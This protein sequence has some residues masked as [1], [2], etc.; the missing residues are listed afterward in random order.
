ML[1]WIR[2][3]VSLRGFLPV[4]A[5]AGMLWALHTCLMP[6]RP[7]YSGAQVRLVEQ[8]A[9]EAARWA[10]A[11]PAGC[12]RTVFGNLE[13]D[14][15]GFVASGVRDALA[16]SGRVDLVDRGFG[17]RLRELISWTTPVTAGAANLARLARRCDAACGIGG[18]VLQFA[19][20][21]SEALLV[22]ELEAV[23]AASRQ[24]LASRRLVLRD[25]LLSLGNG[26]GPPSVPTRLLLW[27]VLLLL[28]PV[29]VVPFS[30][31]LFS[32]GTHLEILAV[33]IALIALDV[34]AAYFLFLRHFSGF[35]AVLLS[36][37][38][39]GVSAFFN[40]RV[41]GFLKERQP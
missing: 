27:L 13:N 15:F 35:I 36:L 28:L 37:A 8:A 14:R 2:L 1:S 4:A 19:D 25:S 18:R 30:A 5:V 6:E 29:A 31:R 7:R 16:R 41:L 38:A 24:V 26:D 23:D 21:P 32:E 40:V 17:E 3:L 12:P 34:L 22:V 10:A 20:T 39:F 9:H 11:L 33:L